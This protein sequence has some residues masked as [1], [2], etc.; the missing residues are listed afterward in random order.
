V[1]LEAAKSRA[2]ALAV[3][4]L[5]L[6]PQDQ[7]TR[8]QQAIAAEPK[9]IRD[10]VSMYILMYGNANPAS[11]I[12]VQ[13]AMPA[14]APSTDRDRHMLERVATIFAGL[15]ILIL[16]GYLLVR[17]QPFADQRLFFA[18]R[19]ILSLASGVFGGTVPGFLSISWKGA[20]MVVRAGGAMALFVLT[21]VYTPGLTP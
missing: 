5:S 8:L 4:I 18:L 14:H 6:S 17:N 13:V 11:S 16:T 12:K 1:N 9:A 15:F 2:E 19:L 3:E 10:I 20:G 7:L 21:F